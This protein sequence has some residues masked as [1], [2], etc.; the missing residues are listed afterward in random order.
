MINSY[1]F[2]LATT[3]IGPGVELKFA[4]AILC[5]A[6]IVC[7]VPEQLYERYKNVVV[8]IHSGMADR[9]ILYIIE[10]AFLSPDVLKERREEARHLVLQDFGPETCVDMFLNA[11]HGS[12]RNYVH[13]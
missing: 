2:F 1:T 7:D 6:C 11:I 5:G 3:S 12:R 4:E 9:E 8:L 10:E 13:R